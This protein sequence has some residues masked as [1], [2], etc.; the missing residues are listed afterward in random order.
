MIDE[1]SVFCDRQTVGTVG[2]DA[3]APSVGPAER[4]PAFSLTPGHGACPTSPGAVSTGR[5]GATATPHS[6]TAGN[7]LAAGWPNPEQHAAIH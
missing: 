1:V 5:I 6:G 3:A 2:T 7:V 4:R